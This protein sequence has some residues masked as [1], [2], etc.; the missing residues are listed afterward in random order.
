MLC[1]ICGKR[2]AIVFIHQVGIGENRELHLC[3]QCAYEHGL[4]HLEGDV[5]KALI[6][7]LKKIPIDNTPLSESIETKGSMQSGKQK[8]KYPDRCPVCG[9]TI[10]DIK[11]TDLAGCETCWELYGELLLSSI[12]RQRSGVPYHGRFSVK[13][14]KSMTLKME[15]EYLKQLLQTAVAMEDYE[16]AAIYRDKIRL[17]E[18]G[19]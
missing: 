3:S 4:Q 2:E 15:L 6:E 13:L 11:K 17:L 19:V 10:Q 5:G 12:K 18:Q 14:S 9:N 8:K 16:Q 7:L 1:D